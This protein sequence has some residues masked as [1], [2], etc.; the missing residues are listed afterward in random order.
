MKAG[1]VQLAGGRDRNLGLLTAWSARWNLNRHD[2]V[3]RAVS[4]HRR[5]NRDWIKAIRH[6]VAINVSVDNNIAEVK[7]VAAQL[8]GRQV[9]FVIAVTGVGNGVWQIDSCTWRSGL[10]LISFNI[11]ASNLLDV[12][13]NEVRRRGAISTATIFI[14]C[15]C[16][17]TNDSAS[18]RCS[19]RSEAWQHDGDKRQ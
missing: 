16:L 8:S 18:W 12:G 6:A 10:V 2:D 15:S 7:V 9:V 19:S 11:N 13:R 4:R 17:V 3:V 1:E 5:S 14:R